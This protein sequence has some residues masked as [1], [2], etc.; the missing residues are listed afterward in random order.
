MKK[1][2]YPPGK[3]IN[4]KSKGKR[5]LE[6]SFICSLLLL[7]ALFYSFKKFDNQAKLFIPKPTTIIVENIP[8]TKPPI[9]INR[10]ELP[11]IPVAS[12]DDEFCEEVP[13]DFGDIDIETLIASSGPP[14]DDT[15]EGI[16]FH[17]AS[18]K[19]VL[20]KRIEPIYPELARKA[21]IDGIVVIKVL[22]DKKGD[23]EIAEI[24]KSIPM[25]D[26]AALDAVKQFK[27]KP[28]KQGDKY[29]KVWM[30]IPFSFKLK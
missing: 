21:D 19:P 24:F 5:I 2:N 22:I 3:V 27:F 20:L 6:I 30:H 29:V 13:V 11:K 16:P 12:E 8:I 23:I 28:G 14:E 18:E 7:S 9:N 25:L 26:K 10:P 17:W 4:Y 15:E 1:Q